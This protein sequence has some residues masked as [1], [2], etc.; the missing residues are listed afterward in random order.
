MDILFMPLRN[1]FLTLSQTPPHLIEALEPV[2][3]L[4]PKHAKPCLNLGMEPRKLEAGTVIGVY[5]PVEDDQIERAGI[6]TRGELPGVCQ[7]HAARCP[8][9]MSTAGTDPTDMPD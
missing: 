8:Q 9:H 3:L 1:L 7:E 4:T 2:P 5:Q 6:K